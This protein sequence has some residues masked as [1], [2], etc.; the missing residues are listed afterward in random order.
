MRA[1]DSA[2]ADRR[3]GPPQRPVIG[4]RRRHQQRGGGGLVQ[5]GEQAAHRESAT[6]ADGRVRAAAGWTDLVV[7]PRR[8]V[9]PLR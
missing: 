9:W 4:H 7:T 5:P 8:G 3:V 1:T 6:G 2:A